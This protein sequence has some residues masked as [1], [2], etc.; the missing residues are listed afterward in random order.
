MSSSSSASKEYSAELTV[1]KKIDIKRWIKEKKSTKQIADI[2]GITYN[3]AYMAIKRLKD[4]P[5]LSMRSKCGRKSKL[6]PESRGI[7]VKMAEEN[8]F[9]SSSKLAASLAQSSNIIISPNTVLRNLKMSVMNQFSPRKVPLISKV[10]KTRRLELANAFL[11]Q[12]L[13]LWERDYLD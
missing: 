5:S 8:H 12:P 2:L 6:S 1:E 4:A 10:N 9:I 7:L 3:H 13:T 11:I